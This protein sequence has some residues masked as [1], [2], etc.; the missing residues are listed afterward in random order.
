M[1]SIL[2]IVLFCISIIFISTNAQAALQLELTQG[3]AGALPIA[4][5]LFAGDTNSQGSPNNLTDIIRNDL[6]NSGRFKLFNNMTQNPTSLSQVDFKYWQDHKIDNLVLGSVRP[7]SGNYEVNVSLLDIFKGISNPSSS[8]IYND[9]FSVKTRDFRRLAH[10]ISDQIY[11]QLTGDKG[12]FSTRIAYVLVEQNPG[13]KARYKLMVADADGYDPR[14]ILI[15][16]EPIMSPSWSPDSKQIAYVSFENRRAGVYISNIASGQRQLVSNL[17]GINGAPAFSPD[18]QKLAMALSNTGQLKIYV[19]DLATH[20]LKKITDGSSIDTEPRW[21]PDGSAIIFTSNR[22]GGP[23]IYRLTLGDGHIQ[24][25]TFDGSY[26]A[27]ASYT[28]DGKQIVFLHLENKLYNVAVQDLSSGNVSF[29]TRNTDDSSPSIAPNG[30]MVLYAIT[31]GYKGI[32]GMSSI[33]G[34]VKLRL[35]SPEGN[36]RDAVWS[37]F[38]S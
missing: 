37:G 5:P 20:D 26:N 13:Q 10:K 15:S 16:T 25:L 27:T 28:P 23:Q 14:A 9:I 4:I 36:V 29:V 38:S 17:P 32:L 2:R 31:E 22:G 34:A 1:K 8:M 6:K 3:I 35:P 18:G 12:I 7:S 21:S 19:M 24:R 30:K 11:E 33:D